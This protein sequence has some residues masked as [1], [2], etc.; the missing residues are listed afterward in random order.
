M[1]LIPTYIS[2]VQAQ[3]ILSSSELLQ[4]I[5]SGHKQ[6]V[7]NSDDRSQ[8]LGILWHIGIKWLIINGINWPGFNSH[9]FTEV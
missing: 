4:I 6:Y 5:I 8:G 3:Q 9:E 2:N 1:V 7:G